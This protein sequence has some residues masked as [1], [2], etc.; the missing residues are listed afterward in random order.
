MVLLGHP[1]KIAVML[2]ET[3]NHQQQ[4]K[5]CKADQ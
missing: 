3:A 5:Y 2:F 1:V 4:T